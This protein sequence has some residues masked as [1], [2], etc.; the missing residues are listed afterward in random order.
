VQGSTTLPYPD[1][2]FCA[3]MKSLPLCNI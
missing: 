3:A 1:G 2:L